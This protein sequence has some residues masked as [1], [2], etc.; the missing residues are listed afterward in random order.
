MA[1]LS[2]VASEV[3]GWSLSSARHTNSWGHILFSKSERGGISLNETVTSSLE[4][5]FRVEKNE[6]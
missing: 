4:R 1:F 3:P 6:L 5:D 2:P